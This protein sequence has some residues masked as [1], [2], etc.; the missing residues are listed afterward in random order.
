MA[1]VLAALADTLGP[2]SPVMAGLWFAAT[3][4]GAALL[5]YVWQRLL[6]R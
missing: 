4:V 1:D 6:Q 2:V 5:V 3:L